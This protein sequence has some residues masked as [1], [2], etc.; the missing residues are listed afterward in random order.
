M[1]V[2]KLVELGYELEAWPQERGEFTIRGGTLILFPVNETSSWQIDFFGN[3]IESIEIYK[4]GKPSGKTDARERALFEY[5]G[6]GD[7]VVHQDHGVGIWRGIR[8]ERGRKYYLI[9]YRG[10]RGGSPDTLMVPVEEK[11]RIAPYI[12]FRVPPITRLGTPFWKRTVAKTKEEAFS[13]AKKLLMLYAAR[14]LEH[15]EPYFP[16]P[17][18][19][20]KVEESFAYTATLSQERVEREIMK[21]LE[22]DAPM[23]RILLGDVGFG[24]TEI[25]V[26]ASVRVAANG[27]QVAV[28]A[29]TTLL[30]DQHYRVWQER[31]RNLPFRVE[32]LSRLESRKEERNVLQAIR[33]GKA[34]IIVGTHRLL[35]RDVLWRR[36]G[37]VIID[38]EQRF[39]VRAKE[40]LKDFKKDIDILTLSATPLPRT[41]SLALASLR[42]M[43]TLEEPPKGRRAPQ[44]FVLPYKR[45]MMLRAVKHELGRQGQVYFLE[46]RI[47]SIPKTLEELRELLPKRSIGYI[48]GR[49]SEKILVE[50]MEKF[51]SGKIEILVSTSIIENGIDLSDVNTLVVS[52]AVLFGLSELHQLRGRVGRGKEESFAYFFYNPKK[53]TDRGR[54]RLDTLSSMQFLGAGPMIAEK[55]LEMRGAGNI[56]GRE[57]SGAARQVG[58][59]LYAQFLAEAVEELR[60]NK[61]ELYMKARS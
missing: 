4:G 22:S 5:L 32:R 30:C 54:E 51:R 14:E 49:L 19:E 1:L 39:G 10:A 37:M 17:E 52:D 8:E 9:E 2:E 16:Y 56:L 33:D 47:R 3:K 38:E 58:L 45:E 44:T 35:S 41:L 40:H 18:F 61:H 15:R 7:Y 57:Q 13:F 21:D 46:P 48:H 50:T 23:D 11:R 24:K 42:R 55:D 36:L 29:P 31:V 60:K 25:A 28:L 27:K 43:S 20:E 12:G 59:N 53:L 34:D 6:D 26:R